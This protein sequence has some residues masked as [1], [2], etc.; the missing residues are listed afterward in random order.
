MQLY[1]NHTLHWT[2]PQG[3]QFRGNILGGR[4]RMEVRAAEPPEQENFEIFQKIFLWKLQTRINL[5][6]VKKLKLLDQI[7]ALWKKTIVWQISEKILK[8]FFWNC[9]KFLILID[10]QKEYQT[11]A[12]NFRELWRKTQL[13]G[14]KFSKIYWENRKNALV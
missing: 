1:R 11:V 6:Y 10:F 14:R 5:S 8:N 4:P 9:K 7:C 2:A 12:L 13:F 3:Y